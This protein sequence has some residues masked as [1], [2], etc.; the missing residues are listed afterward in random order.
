MRAEAEQQHYL[1]RI[2]NQRNALKRMLSD[3]A[4]IEGKLEEAARR[5]TKLAADTLE[6]ARSSLWLLEDNG[7][8]LRCM[9]LYEFPSGRESQGAILHSEDF[10]AYFNAL[11]NDKTISAVDAEHDE[12]TC[13]LRQ[14][15]LQPLGIASMLDAPIRA[16]GRLLGVVC[17]EHIGSPREWHDD[18]AIFAGYLADQFA[19]ML[20]NAERL[21]TFK[22]QQESEKRY[23]RLFEN[24]MEG[25]YQASLE[26][27][28]ITMNPAFARIYGY[29]TPQEMIEAI[30][31][32]ARQLYVSPQDR[33]AF[34]TEIE[35]K[36]IVRNREVLNR[37]KDGQLIWVSVNALAVRDE[38]GKTLYYEGIISDITERK[39]AEEKLR[40]SEERYRTLVD[41]IPGAVYRCD[42]IPPWRM[43]YMSDEIYDISG[44]PASDFVNGAWQDYERIIL[45][46]YRPYV[47]K[48]VAK[49]VKSRKPYVLEYP[50]R[51]ANGSIRWVFERGRAQ[52]DEAGNPLW[53]DGVIVDH[54][55]QKRLQEAILRAK[56][57]WEATF[58]AV[59][60]MIILTDGKNRIMRCNRAASSTFAPRYADLL[61]IP[62]GTLFYGDSAASYRLEETSGITQFP[63]LE[64]WYE[65]SVYPVKITT[66]Q[67]GKVYI[68]KDITTQRQLENALLASQKY[69][70]LGTLAASIAHEINSPLQV[71][72]GASEVLLQRIERDE[73]DKA[74]MRQRIEMINKNGWRVAEIVRSLLTYARSTAGD[75]TT[76]DLNLIVGDA[77]LLIEHQLETWA[78]IRVIT[79]LK[80]GLP[81]LMCDRNRITQVIIN[82]LTNARDAMPNGGKIT[83]RT[84]YDPSKD[85]LLLQIEDTGHGIPSEIRQKIF[86]PFF[87]TKPAGMGTG[88]GLSIIKSIVSAHGGEIELE[89]I[90]E[91]G[92]IFT[93][94]LPRIP[95]DFHPKPNED[96]GSR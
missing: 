93:V 81:P 12:R 38:Q 86:D 85:R 94:S 71:I 61:G 59:P 10:P 26:G 68:I 87:T 11:N 25:I 55:E 73:I 13:E 90:A 7:R 9:A 63:T 22:A 18:E 33:E 74:K 83:I 88:L 36:G 66:E 96:N 23:Q 27:R 16:G 41:N 5:I 24:A 54:S 62:I 60:D 58:D 64:G 35:E 20:I 21:Q 67:Q 84:D 69:V 2:H 80:Q 37:R 42:T 8:I 51:H 17:N 29:D 45:E 30:S 32:I 95:P 6:V 48:I 53:L 78:N 91:G 40:Q 65:V 82:I 34:I 19:Q 50:I 28:Y 31:N 72:T 75:F 4:I 70:D 77:L 47:A 15:Y 76:Q 43:V 14:G 57:E 92:T 39:H 52:Y 79:R 89:S 56:E 46:E 44:Y 1:L 3:E 49:G